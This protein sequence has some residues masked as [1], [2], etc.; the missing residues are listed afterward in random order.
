MSFAVSGE[1]I[2][3]HRPISS[4]LVTVRGATSTD[5]FKG[6]LLTAKNDR[7]QSIMGTWSVANSSLATVACNDIENT[8]V[9]H[10]SADDKSQIEAL[11]HAPSNISRDNTIIRYPIVLLWRVKSIQIIFFLGQR[12]SRLT[13]KSS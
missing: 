9:S 13:V 1:K 3:F 11:W 8:A 6:I 7:D 5:H 2:P 10:S 4:V 12:L